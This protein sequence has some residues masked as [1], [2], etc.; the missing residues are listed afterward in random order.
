M[1]A[2]FF[3]SYGFIVPLHSLGYDRHF[4]QGIPASRASS[5]RFCSFTSTIAGF[6]LSILSSW[7]PLDLEADSCTRFQ[8]RLPCVACAHNDPAE[9]EPPGEHG[10]PGTTLETRCTM[11]AVPASRSARTLGLLGTEEVHE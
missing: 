10:G 1:P 7:L 8:L 6:M 11:A 4:F 3:C 5:N 9:R 2:R